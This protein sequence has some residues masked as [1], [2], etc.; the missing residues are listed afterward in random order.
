MHAYT[1]LRELVKGVGATLV[2][3]QLNPEVFGSAYG[4]FVGRSGASF[5][6]VWDG[7]DSCGFLQS[8]TA[9]GEWEDK[10]PLVR[11]RT[12][13]DFTNLREFLATAEALVTAIEKG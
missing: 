5:R 4:V 10:G 9:G 2:E 8:L 3:E 11:E 1:T 12:R 7:K 13:S 6:L